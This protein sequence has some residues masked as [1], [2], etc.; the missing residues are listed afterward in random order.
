VN[1]LPD[2]GY[3]TLIAYRYHFNVSWVIFVDAMRVLGDFAATIMV[4]TLIYLM[5]S[6]RP[7]PLI[8][9]HHKESLHCERLPSRMPPSD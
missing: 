8:L 4:S 2:Y 6:Q 7:D 9:T 3:P 1:T 5:K